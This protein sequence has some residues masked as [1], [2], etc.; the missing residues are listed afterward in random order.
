MAARATLAESMHAVPGEPAVCELAV[1]NRATAADVFTFAVDGEPAR[2]TGV[3]PGRL[4]LGPGERGVARLTCCV[5]RQPDPPA[6]ALVLRVNV[7]SRME[8]GRPVVAETVLRI[9]PFVDI[10]AALGPSVSS[11]WRSGDHTVTVRNGGNAAVVARLS[12]DRADA[13]L[14][15]AVQP[16]TLAVQPGSSAVSL[17]TATCRNR[18]TKRPEQRHAFVVR[19]QADGARPVVLEGHMLQ[20]PRGWLRRV[21][22]GG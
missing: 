12:V 22:A 3:A 7:R 20:Q 4:Q 9:A 5:P 21:P 8:R 1:E 2:W 6:G 16:T 10:S 17:V 18:L 11:G 19:V 13:D 14:V 15:V